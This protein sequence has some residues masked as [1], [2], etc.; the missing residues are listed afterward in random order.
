MQEIHIMFLGNSDA[1]F[2]RRN[3]GTSKL[4][5]LGYV[6]NSYTDVELC[7]VLQ[8]NLCNASIGGT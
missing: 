8:T 4:N 1:N 5:L 6:H 3:A 7:K 2:R